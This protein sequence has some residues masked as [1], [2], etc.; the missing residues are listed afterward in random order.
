MN[1]QVE[2]DWTSTDGSLQYWLELFS[3]ST[4]QMK[5]LHGIILVPPTAP[6]K[7]LKP[8]V[9]GL[10]WT[11]DHEVVIKK[12]KQTSTTTSFNH[13]TVFAF[14]TFHLYLQY[15]ILV[16]ILAVHPEV[17]I[18]YCTQYL[19]LSTVY[20]CNDKNIKSTQFKVLL[21]VSVVPKY[22]CLWAIGTVC[23]HPTVP[24]VLSDTGTLFGKKKES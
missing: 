12:K 13:C 21:P 23:V 19:V 5:Y 8:S 14:F 2:G 24:T 1:Q 18:I 11:D 20:L 16:S 15:F 7:D 3:N 9:M 4:I 6:L 10:W 17:Y 22:T